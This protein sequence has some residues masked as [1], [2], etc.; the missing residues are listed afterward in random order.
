M[1]PCKYDKLPICFL[2]FLFFYLRFIR[3]IKTSKNREPNYDKDYSG[4]GIYTLKILI[5]YYFLHR[6][7]YKYIYVIFSMKQWQQIH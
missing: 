2:L 6:Y 1:D 4:A 3:N 7:I 5:F